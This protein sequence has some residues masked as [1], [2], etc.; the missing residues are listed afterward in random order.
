MK[1]LSLNLDALSVESFDIAGE[2]AEKG[3]VDAHL[4]VPSN[5]RPRTACCP[6]TFQASCAETCTCP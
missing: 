2:A 6:D 4:F 5:N 3:T 1:K